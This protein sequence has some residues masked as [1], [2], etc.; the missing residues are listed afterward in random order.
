MLGPPKCD[1]SSRQLVTVVAFGDAITSWPVDHVT[2]LT[3]VSMYDY[4]AKR[5]TAGVPSKLETTKPG[6][7]DLG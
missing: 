2:P 3:S 5:P 1:W 6:N 7:N 4:I